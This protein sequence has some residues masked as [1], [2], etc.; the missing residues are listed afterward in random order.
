M[1]NQSYTFQISPFD[2][3]PPCHSEE[4]KTTTFV[5]PNIT[6][7]PDIGLRTV[8]TVRMPKA[9]SLSSTYSQITINGTSLT[10]SKMTVQHSLHRM[11]FGS[12]RPTRVPFLYAHHRSARLVWARVYTDWSVEDWKQVSWSDKS[13]F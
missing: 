10:V 5:M 6:D 9:Q 1:K 12:R 2:Q 4:C 11:G 3:S 7:Y 13:R 8:P